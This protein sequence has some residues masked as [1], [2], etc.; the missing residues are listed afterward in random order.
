[1][2]RLNLKLQ[3]EESCICDLYT[4][5]KPFRCKLALFLKQVKVKYLAHFEK[6]KLFMTEASTQ[7]PIAFSCEIIRDLQQH[8]QQQFLHLNSRAE[9]VTLFQNP[10]AADVAIGPDSLQLELI[11]LQAS[12]LPMNKFKVLVGFISFYQRKNFQI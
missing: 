9:Q 8:F 1:M 4:H 2:K 7:F 3:V 10:F 5:F 12:D 11:E 6:S